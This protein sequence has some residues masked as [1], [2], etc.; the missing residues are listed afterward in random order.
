MGLIMDTLSGRKGSNAHVYG[1]VCLAKS[2][3]PSVRALI[4]WLSKV[5]A[6]SSRSEMH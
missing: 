2:G 4:M 3:I 6:F 5:P 1:L